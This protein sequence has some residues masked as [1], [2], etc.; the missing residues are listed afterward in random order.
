MGSGESASLPQAEAENARSAAP[1]AGGWNF[2]SGGGVYLLTDAEDR[3]IQL[4]AA[5]DL[6]RALI[7]RLAGGKSPGEAASEGASLASGGQEAGKMPAPREAGGEMSVP[8]E[9]AGKMPGALRARPRANLGEIVRRIRWRPAH[10]MFEIT[11]EYHR[12]ARLLMPETYL[13]QVGFG[14]C[15]FVHVDPT[16]GIPRFQVGKLLRSPPGVDLGPFATQADAG[17]FIEILEDA[18]DLCRYY[19][20][21]QQV[22]RGQPCAYFDM[23]KC[24]APCNGSISMDRYREM[25]G[26]ALAFACG[27]RQGA[28]ADWT[29]AMRAAADARAYERAGAVKQLI[30]RARR[31]EHES[32]HLV[33][34]IERF[35]YLIV[36]RGGG[37][38]QVK[39][40]FV[41]AGHLQSGPAVRLKELGA[42]VPGWLEQMKAEPPG[43]ADA[44]LRSERIWLVSHFLFKR[45]TP[46]MFIPAESLGE[47]ARLAEQI[48][49]HFATRRKEE[50]RDLGGE[51]V[52]EA[53]EGGN[54]GK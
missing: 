41:R 29:S 37:T 14:P 26:R 21:L 52:A 39:P 24:P 8:L 19:N 23:G 16:A 33:R 20:I 32:F 1:E 54:V 44:A 27:D 25:I 47:P 43:D 4:A 34:P 36:Q 9:R 35:R 31:I 13:K 30:D 46:G 22:P 18:F 51:A 17:R 40:F 11:V 5:A 15:W 49:E 7:N 53:A 45:E 50:L 3:L 6:K 12:I 38:T 10:S 2:P 48:R 42:A 28:Y